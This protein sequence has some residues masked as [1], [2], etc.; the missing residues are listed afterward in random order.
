M[1]KPYV[2]PVRMM[3]QQETKREN[4]K[5]LVKYPGIGEAAELLGVTRTHIYRVLEGERRS[6]RVEAFAKKKGWL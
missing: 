3:R 4:K 1:C 5:R 2:N 6:P